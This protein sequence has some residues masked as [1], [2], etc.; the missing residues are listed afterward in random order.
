MLSANVSKFDCIMIRAD[1]AGCSPASR[2][3]EAVGETELLTK[4]GEG[5]GNRKL[6]RSIGLGSWCWSAVGRRRMPDRVPL[7]DQKEVISRGDPTKR[8]SFCIRSLGAVSRAYADPGFARLIRLHCQIGPCSHELQVPGLQAARKTL[9]Q[10]ELTL[11]MCNEAPRRRGRP[12]LELIPRR[13]VQARQ[14]L[15]PH[16]RLVPH[17]AMRICDGRSRV[18]GALAGEAARMRQL[19]H[20]RRFSSNASSPTFVI[21][22]KESGLVHGHKRL[23]AAA[24]GKERHSGSRRGITRHRGATT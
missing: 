17:G 7:S 20:L 2:L 21:D 24:F 12:R 19:D 5:D 6:R 9:R 10:P 3:A 4:A 16:G 11:F 8:S 18:R 14:G 15:M 1:T 13:R 22:E 23:S